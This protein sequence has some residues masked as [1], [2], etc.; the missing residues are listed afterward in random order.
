MPQ[1]ARPHHPIH[2]P[3]T[4]GPPRPA[5]AS[6]TVRRCRAGGLLVLGVLLITALAA[7]GM[8]GS[9][10]VAGASPPTTDGTEP[11]PTTTQA[12]PTGQIKGFV[13]LVNCNVSPTTL[14]ADA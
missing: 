10:G 6:R 2:R 4:I 9:S 8:A 1:P 11:H 12:P 14:Y 13:N 7:T 5:R 3:P